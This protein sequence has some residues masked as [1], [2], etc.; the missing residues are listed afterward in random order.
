[1]KVTDF[2]DMMMCSRLTNIVENPATSIFQVESHSSALKI[3]AAARSSKLLV[4][5]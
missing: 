1:M 5:I 2:W 3:K 4:M